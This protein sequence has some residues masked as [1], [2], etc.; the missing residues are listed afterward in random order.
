MIDQRVASRGRTFIGCHQSTF[1][2]YINRMRGYH[3]QKDKVEGWEQ[4]AIPSYYYVP[5]EE[6]YVLRKY[7][8]LSPP[9]WAREFPK[10][11]RDL[12]HGIEDLAAQAHDVSVKI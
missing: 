11:W 4:G 3:S 2:G 6:K 8:P 5:L 7:S 1:T 9:L 10:A 12:N